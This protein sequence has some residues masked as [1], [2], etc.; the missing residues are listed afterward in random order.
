MHEPAAN[1][2]AI[3]GLLK[4]DQYGEGEDEDVDFEGDV[5]GEDVDFRGDVAGENVDFG[6]DVAG[7]DVDFGGDVAGEGDD[8]NFGGDVEDDVDFGGDVAG[9]GYDVNFGGDVDGEEPFN[10]ADRLTMNLYSSGDPCLHFVDIQ[11]GEIL[12]LCLLDV[13]LNLTCPAGATLNL[14]YLKFIFKL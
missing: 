3:I 5:E 10:E 11:R 6:G 1:D 8:V 12:F 13:S 9:E 4:Y 7:E 14:K 2:S